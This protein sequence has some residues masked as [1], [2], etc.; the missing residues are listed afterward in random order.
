MCHVLLVPRHIITLPV[1]PALFGAVKRCT[2]LQFQQQPINGKVSAS[3]TTSKTKISNAKDVKNAKAVAACKSKSR[4]ISTE[5]AT[6]HQ[7]AKHF[8]TNAQ[9]QN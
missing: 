6:S 1:L 5:L 2:S 9:Q 8:N 7:I 4:F 3:T